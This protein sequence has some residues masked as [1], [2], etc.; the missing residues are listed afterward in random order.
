MLTK[1]P[2]GS[3]DLVTT[4]FEYLDKIGH[5]PTRQFLKRLV[6]NDVVLQLQLIVLLNMN[7]MLVKQVFSLSTGNIF[8]DVKQLCEQLK[9]DSE[10]FKNEHRSILGHSTKPTAVKD[11]LVVKQ[12]PISDDKSKAQ[13]FFNAPRM[14]SF[15]DDTDK[16]AEQQTNDSQ[17][18]HPL[19]AVR[20][21]R[22]PIATNT[23]DIFNFFNPPSQPVSVQGNT[24]NFSANNSLRQIQE[25]ISIRPKMFRYSESFGV[26]Q[27]NTLES[28]GSFDPAPREIGGSLGGI[29]QAISSTNT[30]QPRMFTFADEDK[31]SPVQFYTKDPTK[32]Q[33]KD[34]GFG[35]APRMFSFSD[36]VEEVFPHKPQ[37]LPSGDFQHGRPPLRNNSDF[38]GNQFNRGFRNDPPPIFNFSHN[39][40]RSSNA[41]QQRDQPSS[42]PRMFTFADSP[43]RQNDSYKRDM[44]RGNSYRGSNRDNDYR[45]SRRSHKEEAKDYDSIWKSTKD[46]PLWNKLPFIASKFEDDDDRGYKNQAERKPSPDREA[47]RANDDKHMDI[48][49]N[50]NTSGWS[51]DQPRMFTFDSPKKDTQATK[52]S[53]N[54]HAAETFWRGDTNRN[55][56][57]HPKSPKQS[58]KMQ[59]ISIEIKG[60]PEVNMDPS[61]QRVNLPPPRMFQFADNDDDKPGFKSNERNYGSRNSDRFDSHPKPWESKRSSHDDRNHGNKDSRYNDRD[62]RSDSRNSDSFKK[63]GYKPTRDRDQERDAYS[64][65]RKQQHSSLVITRGDSA[66]SQEQPYERRGTRDSPSRY[67]KPTDSHR[68]N[69]SKRRERS[70]SY[71]RKDRERSYNQDARPEPRRTSRSRSRSRSKDKKRSN[72]PSRADKNRRYADSPERGSRRPTL[73]QKIEYSDK[74]RRSSSPTQPNDE[75][76]SKEA[77]SGTDK[78]SKYFQPTRV[79][80][81]PEDPPVDTNKRYFAKREEEKNAK[82]NFASFLAKPFREKESKHEIDDY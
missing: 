20:H 70:G 10:Y 67:E 41:P 46:D 53:S 43:P 69:E 36:D 54:S 45:D 56:K 22:E 81:M 75:N 30:Q 13:S 49:K 38:K 4:E 7:Q 2:L 34:S 64:T 15:S 25:P 74:R 63:E 40:E 48:E 6:Q 24:R 1:K 76:G 51:Y 28:F 19:A 11:S 65:N 31:D 44:P 57:D 77:A 59:E 60:T 78:Y 73:N 68:D 80:Q 26:I 27:D 17:K 50:N 58:E 23:P 35:A 12:P 55:E 5:A 8:A 39:E 18:Y 14:F 71:E 3:W 47:S 52:K 21:P 33:Q 66:K 42:G 72:S 29:I 16:A 61:L 79:F 32:S 9:N 62:N 82:N 37:R